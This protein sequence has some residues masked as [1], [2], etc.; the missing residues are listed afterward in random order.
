MIIHLTKVRSWE[1]NLSHGAK[2]H[3][4]LGL[5]AELD[6]CNCFRKSRFM[7]ASSFRIGTR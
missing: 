2:S 7:L 5:A 4:L 1:H 3:F 6:A